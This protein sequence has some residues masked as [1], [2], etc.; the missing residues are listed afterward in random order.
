MLPAARLL[1]GSLCELVQ[2]T[3]TQQRLSLQIS[4]PRRARNIKVAP[5]KVT[6]SSTCGY[7]SAQSTRGAH[8]GTWYFEIVVTHLGASGHC[9]LGV[10][11]HKQETEAPCGYTDASYAFRDV[12]GSKVHKSLREPYGAGYKE[13]DVIGCARLMPAHGSRARCP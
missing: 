9:R 2:R 12:D 13:G 10:G 1:R 8:S 6:M 3:Y 7:R 11:T 4:R 5:D